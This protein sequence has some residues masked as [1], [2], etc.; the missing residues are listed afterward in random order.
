M[1]YILLLQTVHGASFKSSMES[2]FIPRARSVIAPVGWTSIPPGPCPKGMSLPLL[3]PTPTPTVTPTSI[4]T[5]APTFTPTP[6]STPTQECGA[7]G[8]TKV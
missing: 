8:V 6:T 5:P 3:P 4:P 2:V 1:I 7:Q